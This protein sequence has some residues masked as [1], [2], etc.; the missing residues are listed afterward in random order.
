MNVIFKLLTF[1]WT[2]YSF[3]KRKIFIKNIGEK[4]IVLDVG[5]GDKPFWRA[6][7]IVDK[8]I[9]DN[10][11]R[12]SGSIIYDSN[13]LFM[14]ADVEN[15]P[16]KDKVFDFV[17]CSHL[18]EHVENPDKAISELTRVAKKGYIEVPNAILELLQPFPPHLWFC[19]YDNNTLIFKQKEKKNELLI[20][21]IGEFGKYIYNNNI[22]QYLLTRHINNIFICLYWKDEFKYKV[23]KL[24]DKGNVY[25]YIEKETNTKNLFLRISFIIYKLLYKTMVFL[26]YKKK[27]IKIDKLLK[28]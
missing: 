13:K 21:N 15:L 7:V 14:N 20:N 6:D 4:D 26:F 5:S 9:N 11:Q 3:F 17:F 16:F 25:K 19:M 18:L 1:F 23:L 8:Y 10:Q 27:N 12:H 22:F 24:K 2:F 28:K